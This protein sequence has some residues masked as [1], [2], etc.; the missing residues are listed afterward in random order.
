MPCPHCGETVDDA[1]EA[2]ERVCIANLLAAALKAAVKEHGDSHSGGN[3]LEIPLCPHDHEWRARSV[4]H[5][6]MNVTANNLA[7]TFLKVDR[8]DN[9][10]SAL[11][12]RI[13]GNAILKA[14]NST[15][16]FPEVKKKRA[17][18]PVGNMARM[19]ITDPKVLPALFVIFYD[20][21]TAAEKASLGALVVATIAA[22]EVVGAAEAAAAPAPSA[23]ATSGAKSKNAKK[24]AHIDEDDVGLP[25]GKACTSADVLAYKQART[26]STKA[27]VPVTAPAPVPAPAPKTGRKS[28]AK[29]P[30]PAAA[31]APTPPPPA[32]DDA[33][34]D[35]EEDEEGGN[36]LHATE[37]GLS[38][39]LEELDED[40]VVGGASTAIDC[41]LTSILY[42]TALH[43]RVKND[44][45][46]TDE[47]K[48]Y[49]SR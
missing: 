8:R 6:R 40:E 39:E 19:F 36:T 14:V 4:L 10:P 47:R 26:K 34:T 48:E 41:W 33:T 13:L 12:K 15:W 23:A 29:A 5:K 35:E 46:G 21:M 2:K 3:I 37:L 22:A 20:E 45:P 24:R 31:P 49:G 25:G 7:I 30:H 32:T 1:F 28:R 18:V 16:F 11:R 9:W 27:P 44:W 17:S 42:L 38:E 43:Q